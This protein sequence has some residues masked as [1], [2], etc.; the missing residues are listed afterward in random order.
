VPQLRQDLATR[1]WSIIA[2]ERSK[3]PDDFTGRLC[4]TEPL[5]SYLSGCPFCP[6]N[7]HL[8]P[9]PVLV[10]PDPGRPDPGRPG[11]AWKI[12][13]VPNKFPALAI[14]SI[15][16][17]ARRR[18]RQGLYL[19]MDGCGQHEVVIETPDHSRTVAT[20]TV[21]EVE[22]VVRTYRER[23]LA[24]D[25]MDWNQLIIIFRN[26]GEVAGTS[27]AHPHSQIVGTPI[28]PEDI[29]G[30]L[31]EAQRYFDDN[32]TCVYCDMLGAELAE[33]AR[34]VSHNAGFVAFCPYASTVPYAM[35]IVPR[36]HASSFG[37]LTDDEAALLAM[38]LQDSLGRLHRLLANPDYNYVIRSA[39]HH[40]AGEPHFH[41]YLEILPRLTTQAGFEIGSGISINVV[42]PENAAKQ[43]REIG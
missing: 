7:E 40:S 31:E 15:G 28:V 32:G 2:T 43:L 1:R 21:E 5:P 8:T 42:V 20:M 30:R 19:E 4:A 17:E 24:M 14:P 41:W 33:G 39:P 35:W 38:V 6:G 18:R 16:G 36:R 23:F 37:V 3:R 22:A 10:V 34:L 9:Q 29:R 13:V 26:Q 27:L 12:R 11:G 25:A